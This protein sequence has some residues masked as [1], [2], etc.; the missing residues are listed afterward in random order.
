MKKIAVFGA[1]GM[2]GKP[3]VCQLVSSGFEVTAMVR[4]PEKARSL[5]P[6]E[7]LLIRGDLGNPEDI[8]QA[9][10]N[11]EAIYINLSVFPSSREKD[12]Q[13]ERE[14][15]RN[16]IDSAKRSGVQ[17]IAYCASL[18]QKYQGMNGFDWWAFRL[19]NTSIGWIKD[20]G[21]P[22]LIFYP[23]TF[24]ENYDR[25]AYIRGNKITIVG[26]S[27]YP[28][29]F[30]AGK[31]FGQQVARAFQQFDGASREYSVQGP[32][33]FLSDQAAEI[34]MEHCI[35]K[36]LGISRLPMGVLKFLA[37]F[38]ATFSYGKYIVEALNK[39]PEQ[40]ESED[41]WKKL[42][43]PRITLQQYATDPKARI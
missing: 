27:E 40:F 29:Y 20:S 34:Y 11:A 8:D 6:E 17:C 15:I 22:S 24:M 42:G 2:I 31:D 43:K 19:K 10:K 26:K 14:G 30:I 33:G 3:V 13:P 7:V 35:E 23:S 9:L 37:N 12:F 36:K 5:L 39:Y 18:V 41:T 16:L 38:G 25:G 32:E 21:I 1:T 28:Q 4:D